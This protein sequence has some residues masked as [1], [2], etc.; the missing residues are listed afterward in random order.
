[1]STVYIESENGVTIDQLIR[2][3]QDAKNTLGGDTVVVAGGESDCAYRDIS[4]VIPNYVERFG[5]TYEF[6]GNP[7]EDEDEGNQVVLTILLRE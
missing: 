7:D 3:L 5:G 4:L 1:M 6:A 2:A